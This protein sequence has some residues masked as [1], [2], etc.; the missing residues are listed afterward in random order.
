MS[1]IESRLIAGQD[2][3][4]AGFNNLADEWADSR[5]VERFSDY[6]IRDSFT[7]ASA[8]DLANNEKVMVT[9]LDTG[10]HTASI[11][12]VGA[13]SNQ[14]PNSGYF[15]YNSGMNKLIRIAPLESEI[16]QRWAEGT[17]PGGNGTKSAK[18]WADDAR[19]TAD[20]VVAINQTALNLKL[21]ISDAS[22]GSFPIT[23]A[24][25]LKSSLNIA[26]GR[27]S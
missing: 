20:E 19:D 16:A 8:L 25:Q 5:R 14:T 10:T 11:G 12:D 2:L 27:I 9:A 21:N 24:N 26:L 22:S 1:T 23:L 6:R 15:Y 7:Q 3:T 18:E 13:V 4:T 17:L